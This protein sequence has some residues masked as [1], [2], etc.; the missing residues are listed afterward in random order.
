MKKLR[1]A[2]LVALAFASCQKIE[3]TTTEVKEEQPIVEATPAPTTPVSKPIAAATPT[4]TPTDTQVITA[5]APA[6]APERAMAIPVAVRAQAA[7]TPFAANTA[8]AS[9]APPAPAKP[10][11]FAGFG[12]SSNGLSAQPKAYNQRKAFVD[13][14]GDGRKFD[15]HQQPRARSTPAPPR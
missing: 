8:A 11:P 2:A 4:V 6:P 14:D 9:A 15:T 7:P 5:A 3:K 13:T 1:I 10:T 12:N